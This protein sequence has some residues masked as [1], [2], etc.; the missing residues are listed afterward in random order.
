MSL[1]GLRSSLPMHVDFSAVGLDAETQALLRQ[2]RHEFEAVLGT[3]VE[4]GAGPAG[5]PRWVI[6]PLDEGAAPALA[7]DACTQTLASRANTASHLMDTLQLLHTLAHSPASS[8]RA[9]PAT[10]VE[11]AV[12]VLDAECRNTYPSFALRGLAWDRLSE[13]AARERPTTWEGFRDWA[14]HWVARLGDAHTAVIDHSR[15]AFNPPYTAELIGGRARLLIVPE[16]SAAHTA[17]VRAGWEIPVDVAGHWLSTTGASPQQHARMAARRFLAVVGE[18]RE[19][20]AVD[21]ATGRAA[22]WEE[23]RRP[24]RLEDVVTVARNASGTVVVTLREFRAGM[25]VESVFDELVAGSTAGGHLILDLRGNTGGDILLAGRLRDRFLREE[26]TLGSIAFTDGRGGLGPRRLREA[27]PSEEPRWAGRLTVLTDASTYS[28]SEDFLLGLQGLE[29]V[30]VLGAR[31]GG[32]SG[33]PRTL[34]L[35][36]T[37]SLRISTA[38]TYDR[39]GRPVE[40]RGIVPDRALAVPVSAL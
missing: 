24:P 8:V 33:R 38:I 17:G 31:T 35:S 26:T 37:T 36:P 14:T 3:A 4:F 13:Q 2:E 40:F 19:F 11:A 29:H 1:A 7:W 15:P 5:G 23:T 22:T 39:A 16:T 34:P 21:P 9:V 25:G 27:A 32:G 20:A 18:T 10:S 12:A 6:D 30:T 28:A